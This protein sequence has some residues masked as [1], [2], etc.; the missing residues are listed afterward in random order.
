MENFTV[1]PFIF[2]YG[3][4]VVVLLASATTVTAI[5]YVRGKRKAVHPIEKHNNRV[6][7]EFLTVLIILLLG[8]TAVLVVDLTVR[9]P[10]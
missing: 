10:N 8:C 9:H 4:A 6:T 3:L 5:C 7:G 2:F 1:S